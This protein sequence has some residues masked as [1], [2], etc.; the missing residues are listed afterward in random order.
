MTTIREP[1]VAGLFYPEDADLLRRSLSEMLNKA[2][3]SHI[4]PR[5]IIAPHAGYIYSGKVAATAYRLLEPM[6]D[7]VRRVVLLGPAHRVALSGCALSRSEYFRTPLG[8]I[9]VDT[10]AVQNLLQNSNIQLSDL[11]H[12]DEHSLEVHLPFLQTVLNVFLLVPIVVGQ[13]DADAVMEVL[14]FFWV[15]LQHFLL[16]ALI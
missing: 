10:E 1:A 7:K 3:V 8:D 13:M 12:Q 4:E 16:S 11:A 9:P 6:K 5:A 2:P 15:T 14:E